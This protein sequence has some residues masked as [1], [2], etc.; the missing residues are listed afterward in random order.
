MEVPGGERV[1]HTTAKHARQ[2]LHMVGLLIAAG[3]LLGQWSVAHAQQAPASR[4]VSED[5]TTEPDG[6]RALVNRAVEAHQAGNFAVARGLFEQAH[7]L[8][9]NARTFRGLGVV[10]LEM[11]TYVEAETLLVQA[12]ESN[13][14]PLDSELR[15]SSQELLERARSFLGRV[16]LVVSP[17]ETE[18][19]LDGRTLA[20]LGAP[21]LLEH[22]E[23]I[24][25]FRAQGFLPQQRPL[26][27]LAGD[28]LLLH[29]VL[30]PQPAVRDAQPR[31]S[32][33]RGI[34]K[35]P[36]LWSIVG[37]AVAGGVA[38]AVL[39]ARRD[40]GYDGGSTAQVVGAR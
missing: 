25:D 4:G 21:L 26:Q 20:L 16:Q 12:L 29:V 10:A 5:A 3:V 7:A 28:E 1:R 14:R 11:H 34:I 38:A 30:T 39:L 17:E 15:A 6:Y 8:Y 40:T 18:A 24:F 22:G 19:A 36:W 23:H 35:S 31:V 2:R 13:V 32:S 27:V 9:P 37:V 33:E